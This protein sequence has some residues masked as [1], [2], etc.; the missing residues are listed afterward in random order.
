MFEHVIALPPAILYNFLYLLNYGTLLNLI[1]KTN[2]PKMPLS[3]SL[4]NPYLSTSFTL[5]IFKKKSIIEYLFFS[6]ILY[7]TCLIFEI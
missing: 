5:Q 7:L 4:K 2:T 6:M 1:L 3:L